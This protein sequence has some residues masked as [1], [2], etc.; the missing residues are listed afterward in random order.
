MSDLVI[1][2][3]TKTDLPDIVAMLAD[4]FLGAAREMPS[5]MAPYYAAFERVS[6]EAN[7]HLMV[8]EAGGALV[9]SHHGYKMALT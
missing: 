1:R 6:A 2:P 5:D 7:Q 4:D 8:A 9:H 3:A